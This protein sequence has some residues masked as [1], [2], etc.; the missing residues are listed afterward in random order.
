MNKKLV[1]HKGKLRVLMLLAVLAVVAVIVVLAYDE[2]EVGSIYASYDYEAYQPYAHEPMYADGY[3]TSGDN[4]VYYQEGYPYTY[5]V[6]YEPYY[7]VDYNNAGYMNYAPGYYYDQGYVGYAPYYIGIEPL[8]L[9]ATVYNITDLV[10]RVGAVPANGVAHTIPLGASFTTT[11]NS[12]IAITGNRNIILASAGATTQ[13][14][15]QHM[16]GQRHFI[17]SGG[18]RLEIQNVHL[19]REDGFGANVISGGIDVTGT[20]SRLEM[21]HA[22][23]IISNNRARMG[24]GVNVIS[25]A[26]FFMSNGR[27]IGNTAVRDA[28]N[29]AGGEG[30][31]VNVTGGTATVYS[32]FRMTGGIIGGTAPGMRNTANRGGG[33]S[34]S[35]GARFH[36]VADGA[37]Y[38]IIEGNFA[39]SPATTGHSGNGGGV[40]IDGNNNTHTRFVFSA[41]TIRYN[42]ADEGGGIVL[43]RYAT[44]AMSGTARIESNIADGP[45][46]N[47]DGV[48]GG[49]YISWRATFDMYDG[50]IYN[51][52]SIM[53]HGNIALH[54]SGNN[55]GGAIRIIGESVFTMHGGLID[56]NRALHSLGGAFSISDSTVRI[57]D[58]TISNN[59][60]RGG[61]GIRTGSDS[62]VYMYGGVIRDNIAVYTI[63]PAR[64]FAGHGGGILAGGAGTRVEINGGTIYNNRAQYG[65]GVRVSGT[66]VNMRGGTIHSN[67][68]A[69]LAPNTTAVSAGGGLHATGTAGI[70]TMTGGTIGHT[71][72]ALGNRAQSGGGVFVIDGATFNMQ[73]GVGTAGT[74]VGNTSVNT[75]SN[76]GGGGVFVDQPGSSFTMSAGTIRSNIANNMAGLTQ[77]G[78]GGVHVRN[79]ATFTMTGGVIGG[80][81]P[82][83]ANTA[84]RGGGVLVGTNGTFVMNTTTGII[85]GNVAAGTTGGCGGGGVFV[86]GAQD[87][88]DGVATF[89]LIDGIIGGDSTLGEGNT[90]P[91]GGGVFIHNSGD[92]VMSG[93]RISGNLA[94]GCGGGV[95]LGTRGDAV[96]YNTFLMTGGTIGGTGGLR[97]TAGVGGGVRV[98]STSHFTLDGGDIYN[99][100]SATGGGVLV[101]PNASLNMISGYIR[102]NVATGSISTHGGGGIHLLADSTFTMSGGNIERNHAHQGGGVFLSGNNSLFRLYGTDPK[103]ITGNEADY[104]GGV[105]VHQ[106]GFM[107]MQPNSSNLHITNNTAA[108]LGGGIFTARYQYTSPITRLYPAYAMAVAAY[109]NLTLVH[110]TFS[111][112]QAN[113]LHTPPSNALTAGHLPNLMGFSSTS[114][115]ANPAPA[116]VHP[117]NN[118]DINF[119][120]TGVRFEFFKT[121]ASTDTPPDSLLAGARFR[122]FRTT[123]TDLPTGTSGFVTFDSS[124]NPLAPWQELSMAVNVS[125]AGPLAQAVAFYMN[126]GFTYQLIEYLAPVGFQ[127][128]MGQWRMWLDTSDPLD[129]T[130]QTMIISDLS[131]PDFVY[132]DTAFNDVYRFLPNWVQLQ[133]PLTGGTGTMLFVL[134]GTSVV[135]IALMVVAV[136]KMKKANAAPA[137]I[138]SVRKL[139]GL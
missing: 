67:R 39:T 55:G 6:Q 124:G 8:V 94:P 11:A 5:Y 125:Q 63:D 51:N 93:G 62:I 40:H 101:L 28:N 52:E 15:N 53:G 71:D 22:D 31:G 89:H 117:L 107:T 109:R 33:V 139:E 99:N 85:K 49:I 121:G 76:T 12:A 69:L 115:P 90:G 23:G 30:G 78:G 126:P 137:D 26:R 35:N 2:Y 77:H 38:G 17:V 20:N 45:R 72:L 119:S 16:S 122:V 135:V 108:Y 21:T 47:N 132:R 97:N 131:M 56:N 66:I 24:G 57:Y 102:D 80:S 127:P 95:C 104:G 136:F 81:A 112:N 86:T 82:E 37:S 65:A 123:A 59:R 25:N 29:I 4:H 96:T 70:F 98:G 113:Q 61:G 87:R 43:W 100:L 118:Y 68:Y 116:I 130:I 14:W 27:I 88:Q 92:F 110:V 73:A 9:M 75:V 128:P 48:G 41:G 74:I 133:L 134:A 46:L 50:T 36:M 79:F 18:A 83:Y 64:V 114:Q 58:G 54:G 3:Y 44:G 129:V 60:A 7:E 10:N 103:H 111:G 138:V 19:S 13:R 106:N 84:V 120:L 1:A 42:E 105:W 32:F 34:V 91:H